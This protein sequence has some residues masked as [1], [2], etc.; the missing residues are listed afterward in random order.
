MNVLKRTKKK[1]F[2]NPFYKGRGVL[3][4]VLDNK[5]IIAFDDFA[6]QQLNEWKAIRGSELDAPSQ[7]GEGETSSGN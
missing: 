7:R 1:M 4:V 2:F 5:K 6:L 3:Y